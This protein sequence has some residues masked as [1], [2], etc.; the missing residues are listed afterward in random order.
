[1]N[2]VG[3]SSVPQRAYLLYTGVDSVA[4]AD[5]EVYYTPGFSIPSIGDWTFCSEPTFDGTRP[6]WPVGDS[7]ASAR[8]VT[9]PLT[10][11]PNGIVVL[12]AIDL[13][14]GAT[15]ELHAWGTPEFAP[16][17]GRRVV[18]K[19]RPPKAADCFNPLLAGL[20]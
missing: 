17:T 13:A 6:P 7:V 3:D 12:G 18:A 10:A 16:S 19:M 14:A 2:L 15:G 8:W 4:I 9:K 20:S 5:F 11:T 1:V